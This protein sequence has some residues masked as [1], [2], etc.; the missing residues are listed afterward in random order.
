M[1]ESQFDPKKLGEQPEMLELGSHPE[2]QRLGEH[3][4]PDRLPA[5]EEEAKAAAAPAVEKFAATSDA[6][7]A[8][9]IF[10]GMGWVALLILGLMVAAALI[11]R[12]RITE[13]GGYANFYGT[14]M[15]SPAYADADVEEY[16]SLDE[17]MANANPAVAKAGPA[18]AASSAASAATSTSST[19]APTAVVVYLFDT[20]RSNVPE[21]ASLTNIARQAVKSGKT[22]VI[23]AYTDETGN[24][25][26]NTRLSERRARS[27]GDYMVAHGVPSAKVRAKGCGPT[28]A[29]A[30]NAQD[31]RAEVSLE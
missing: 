17:I 18:A 28:H 30:S 9:G 2:A 19:A 4:E 26:Y 3:R 7:E 8:R 16:I 25:A 13:A 10:G 27:V 6:Q 12:P 15:P 22:V 23:K 1:K 11:W 14:Q 5:H 24:A 31:R 29:Y 20:D 21:T